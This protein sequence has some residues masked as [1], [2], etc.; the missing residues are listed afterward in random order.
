MGE[1]TSSGGVELQTHRAESMRKVIECQKGSS[2]ADT[3]MKYEEK[4]ENN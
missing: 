3:C 2:E 4:E 1:D